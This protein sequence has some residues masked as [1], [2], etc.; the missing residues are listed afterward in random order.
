[1]LLVD[2]L[3]LLTSLPTLKGTP[4]FLSWVLSW[5]DMTL[6]G[7]TYV[8]T[9]DQSLTPYEPYPSHLTP[10]RSTWPSSDP[11]PSADAGLLDDHALLG[12]VHPTLLSP[13]PHLV[14]GPSHIPCTSLPSFHLT[15]VPYPTHRLVSHTLLSVP[16]LRPSPL[17]LGPFYGPL[18]FTYIFGTKLLLAYQPIGSFPDG[19]CKPHALCF[20]L[21]PILA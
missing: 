14:V 15:S 8:I 18:A 1:M 19:C 17:A 10:A 6:P 12:R 3:S 21:F 4:W 11:I 9:P 20:T 7:Y 16:Q 13:F 2:T 5:P